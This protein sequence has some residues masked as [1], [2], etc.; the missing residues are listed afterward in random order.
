MFAQGGMGQFI[1]PTDHTYHA[2]TLKFLS[3]L[4]VEIIRGPRF[5]EGYISFYLQGQFY[6][7]NLNVFHE[8]FGLSLIHI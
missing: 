7:L 6:E 4:N 3:M 1:E 5:Q 8:I 2:L